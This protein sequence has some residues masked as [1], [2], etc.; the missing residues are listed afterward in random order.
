MRKAILPVLLLMFSFQAVPQVRLFMVEPM[1]GLVAV[2]NFGSSTVNVDAYWLTARASSK[3][4][5]SMLIMSGSLVMA[6]GDTLI[7]AGLTMNITSSDLGFFLTSAFTDT[8]Q[9]L[10]FMQYG[11]GGIGTEP[12]AA[13]KGIWNAGDFVTGLAP[14]TYV[15][16][17]TTNWGVGY[18]STNSPP[19]AA[20]SSSS[21]FACLND[22]VTFTHSTTGTVLTWNWNFGPGATPA[23]AA[24]PG[25][26][27]VTYSSIGAKQVTLI[28]SNPFGSDTALQNIVIDTSVGVSVSG[29]SSLCEGDT[30]TLDA[31]TGYDS[32]LWST[33]ETTQTIR[34]SAGGSYSVTVTK[35]S[36]SG[37]AA[38]SVTAYPSA[39]KPLLNYDG[40]LNLLWVDSVY[41]A[42]NWFRDGSSVGGGSSTFTPLV[43]GAYY[44]LVADTNGCSAFSD[45]MTITVGISHKP[46]QVQL[47]ARPN[48][49]GDHL[50]ISFP[51]GTDA[52]VTILNSIGQSI[53]LKPGP[54]GRIDTSF[55]EPGIYILRMAGEWGCAAEVFIVN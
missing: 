44:V 39:I 52:E 27:A 26:H 25:P 29:P 7:M 55:L 45:T 22:T 40:G 20:F 17:G 41:A 15:G 5:N 9:M 14:W 51:P 16:N 19:S 47:S 33:N 32:Y 38:K 42:Y 48:P 1:M 35:A 11:G 37:S 4:L 43:T 6:P 28:A 50:I 8:S 2:K 23:A 24:A 21:N 10:D 18:W 3:Q 53:R 46:V 36:C 34:A 13:S 12:V 54:G 30:V 31:G 49:A